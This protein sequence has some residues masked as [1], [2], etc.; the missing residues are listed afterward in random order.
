GIASSEYNPE[1]WAGTFDDVLGTS[2][3]NWSGPKTDGTVNG[4]FT[5]P[6]SIGW[7]STYTLTFTDPDMRITSCTSNNGTLNYDSDSISL[8]NWN[9][10]GIS[11]NLTI[12]ASLNITGLYDKVF[13]G[14]NTSSDG[15]GVQYY[16]GDVVPNSV[17]ELYATWTTPDLFEN[18]SFTFDGNRTVT[19]SVSKMFL[20]YLS[21]TSTGNLSTTPFDGSKGMYS[22]IYLL[23][24][25]ISFTSISNLP[26]GTYRSFNVESPVN[27]TLGKNSLSGGAIFDN[28]NLK[29][30]GGLSGTHG[31]HTNYGLFA[32]G[33]VLI[34]GTNIGTDA[35]E[36]NRTAQIVGGAH[37]GSITSAA[38]SNKTIV[39]NSSDNFLG[40]TVNLGT[41]VIIHSGIYQN[42]AAG[43]ITS[44]VGSSSVP[45]STYLVMKG[46]TVLD[47]VIGGSGGEGSYPIT[48]VA[49]ESSVIN[50][51]CG[52]T[53]VYLLGCNAPGDDYQEI[54]AGYR[55]Y[56]Y[57][58]N[59]PVESIGEST[60]IEG[61]ASS[62]TVVGSSHV[63]VSDDATVWDVQAGGRRS[64]TSTTFA[65]M[66]IS[67]NAIIK[68]LACGTITDGNGSGTRN[69]V[70][71]AHIVV[72]GSPKIASLFGA[73]YDT[74]TISKYSSFIG[75]AGGNIDGSGIG[76]ID[77]DVKGGTIGYVYGG[78]YR[79]TIGTADR[80]VDVMIDI[81]GG[82]VLYDVF[83]GGRGG[84]EKVLHRNVREHNTSYGTIVNRGNT[85]TTGQSFVYGDIDINIGG[86]AVIIGSVYGG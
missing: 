74:W 42:I 63:F 50:E 64:Q 4:S 3:Q 27:V 16:P 67:G 54:A 68:H 33:K 12:T 21:V 19:D 72:E 1:H 24:G 86:N 56:Q 80:P 78:G 46:G 48:A 10:S 65:F 34:L 9:N 47:T 14:W 70:G 37:S 73:G 32:N 22:T 23:R 85:Q 60:I 49:N 59:N 38:V 26:T 77:V 52:G 30:G 76:K 40:S 61:G 51:K 7:N 58:V 71:G 20:P 11:G 35:T 6:Y 2:V 8:Q 43:G 45:L 25:N 62:G 28:L 79:G 82:T 44:S 83:G 39:S 5:I 53:F 66:E 15:T 41:Y 31:D 29:N 13:S 57:Y 69:S 36:W 18:I 17:S 81:T 84:L 75:R 55:P